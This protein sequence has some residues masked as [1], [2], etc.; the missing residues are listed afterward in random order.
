M[1]FFLPDEIVVGMARAPMVPNRRLLIYQGI[2]RNYKQQQLSITYFRSK[3][4]KFLRT[5]K[6]V[7]HGSQFPVLWSQLFR[8]TRDYQDFL[9]SVARIQD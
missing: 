2:R 7:I 6:T 1:I 4:A 9:V 3:H 5:E 8:T